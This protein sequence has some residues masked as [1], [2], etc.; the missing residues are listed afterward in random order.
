LDIRSYRK[1]RACFKKYKNTMKLYN[2][3]EETD[4]QKLYFEKISHFFGIPP[5]LFGVIIFGIWQAVCVLTKYLSLGS[6]PLFEIYNASSWWIAYVLVVIFLLHIK[7]KYIKIIKS[8]NLPKEEQQKLIH[9][10]PNKTLRISLIVGSTLYCMVLQIIFYAFVLK[11]PLSFVSPLNFIAWWIF[12]P[13]CGIAAGEFLAE[14]IEIG[15]LPWR[16]RNKVKINVFHYDLY[17]GLKVISELF[18]HLIIAVALLIVFFSLTSFTSKLAG[19]NEELTLFWLLGDV[20]WGTLG[21][22]SLFVVPQIFLS[23]AM[24][25]SK[26]KEL[27]KHYQNLVPLGSSDGSQEVLAR[28]YNVILYKEIQKMHEYPF[29][30]RELEKAV[31]VAIIPAIQKL[32]P[33]LLMY[34][35]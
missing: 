11:T 3:S 24:K 16:I 2:N 10:F 20:G 14:V 21:I 1:L 5:V 34:L 17:G 33:F 29:G 9:S 6:I 23:K 27:D 22:M 15:G 32:L 8:I 4:G 35:K 7:T 26:Y 18:T 31:V 19:V 25:E 12:L 30:M 13:F 28:I